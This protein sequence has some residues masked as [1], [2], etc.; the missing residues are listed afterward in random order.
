MPPEFLK[1]PDSAR[2]PACG[3]PAMTYRY[4]IVCEF[5]SAILQGRECEPSFAQGAAAQVVADAVLQSSA[6]AGWVELPRAKM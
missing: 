1:L 5:G 4:D 3:D 6:G 2:D